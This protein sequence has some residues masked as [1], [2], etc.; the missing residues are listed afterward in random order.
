MSPAAAS[1]AVLVPEAKEGEFVFSAANADFQQGWSG[2]AWYG[3]GTMTKNADGSF[4]YDASFTHAFRYRP[5]YKWIDFTVLDSRIL[6]DGG[7]KSWGLGLYKYMGP[8]FGNVHTVRTGLYTLPLKPL[9]KPLDDYLRLDSINY[10]VTLGYVRF[11]AEPPTR[12]SVWKKGE[13]VQRCDRVS[14]GDTLVFELVLERPAE[15][16]AC[17]FELSNGNAPVPVAVNGAASV[18]LKCLDDRGCRWGAELPVKAVAR[19]KNVPVA[20]VTTL[21][22]D[23]RTIYTRFPGPLFK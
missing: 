12:F 22:G 7:Y 23:S 10:G 5:E 17:R 16:V 9:E 8:L 1:T 18:E 14:A 4:A 3:K 13:S 6:H 19:T 11:S 2:K 20:V 21:G 15:D